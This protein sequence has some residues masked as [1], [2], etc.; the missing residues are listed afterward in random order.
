M[1]LQTNVNTFPTLSYANDGVSVPDSFDSRTKWGSCI[2]PVLNQ[3]ECG[4]CW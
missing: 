4:S 2:G 3:A 1:S